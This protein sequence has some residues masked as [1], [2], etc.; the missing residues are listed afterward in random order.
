M[1]HSPYEVAKRKGH[2]NMLQLMSAAEQRKGKVSMSCMLSLQSAMGMLNKN[3]ANTYYF[4]SRR[5][6]LASSLL[7]MKSLSMTCSMGIQLE[8][9]AVESST[10]A[11]GYQEISRWL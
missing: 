9:V 1:G 7:G 4:H 5:A 3:Q 6:P 10:R 8:G 2:H 11:C